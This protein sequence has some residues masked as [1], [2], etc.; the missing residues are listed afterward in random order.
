[1]LKPAESKA[2]SQKREQAL[3]SAVSETTRLAVLRLLVDGQQWTV[4]QLAMEFHRPLDSM[5][6]HLRILNNFDILQIV[7]V[8]NVD[9]RLVH[10]RLPERFITTNS[11]G[12]RFLDF[13]PVLFRL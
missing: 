8:E 13:G 6:R 11:D 1:M 9:G 10:Y 12:S 3:I 2:L 5:A 4:T 7:K